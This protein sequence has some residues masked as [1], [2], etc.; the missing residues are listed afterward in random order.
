MII[1]LR[2]IIDNRNMTV[3]ELAK[4]A[5]LGRTLVS[6]LSN[7]DSLPPKTKMDSL[8]KI[9][10]ALEIDLNTLIEEEI[11]IEITVNKTISLKTN[12]ILLFA[13]K[14]KGEFR[15]Y[16]VLCI[17]RVRYTP[18]NKDSFNSPNPNSAVLNFEVLNAE[19]IE[20]LA[21]TE[22]LLNDELIAGFNQQFNLDSQNEFREIEDKKIFYIISKLICVYIIENQ[23]FS[24]KSL[25]IENIRSF[26]NLGP[27]DFLRYS[28]NFSNGELK[29]IKLK[30]SSNQQAQ[31]VK[32]IVLDYQQQKK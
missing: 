16:T 15:A 11:K 2:K 25:K 12:A 9:C 7:S 29:E 21:D 26:W 4:K 14:I 31:L 28:F 32:K 19:D 24:D 13:V 22:Q 20:Y 30:S 27:S 6:E 8:M 5:N 10:S 3:S 17:A 1:N 23:V 18:P